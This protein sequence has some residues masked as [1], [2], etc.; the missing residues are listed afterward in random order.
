MKEPILWENF[1]KLHLTPTSISPYVITKLQS[2]KKSQK[3]VHIS[4]NC[5]QFDKFLEQHLTK[6]AHFIFFSITS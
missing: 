1:N 3:K 6:Y 4:L 5:P 2:E